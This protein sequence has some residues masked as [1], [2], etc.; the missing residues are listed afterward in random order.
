MVDE[1]GSRNRFSLEGVRCGG[2]D[3]DS[4]RREQRGVTER[5]ATFVAGHTDLTT[6]SIERD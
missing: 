1:G 2:S 3:H 4:K 6:V 5:Q